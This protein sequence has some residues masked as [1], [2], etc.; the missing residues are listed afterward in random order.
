MESLKLEG[1]TIRGV[2][3]GRTI[4]CVVSSEPA[5]LELPRGQYWLSAAEKSPIYGQLLSIEAKHG[6]GAAPGASREKMAAPAALKDSPA[7]VATLV[8]GGQGSTIAASGD[9][10]IKFAPGYVKDAAPGY[11]KD[12]PAGKFFDG[13]NTSGTSR[14]IIA[15]K[16]IGQNS[17]VAHAGFSDLAETVQR[18]GGIALIVE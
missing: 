18:A 8:P 11:V 1:R 6:P 7:A 16:P 2:V 14:V 17:L 5:G 9:F 13:A 10:H 4:N 12:A 3:H 15:A